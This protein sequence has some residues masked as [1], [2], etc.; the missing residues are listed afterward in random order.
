MSRALR[1]FHYSQNLYLICGAQL[2]GSRHAQSQLILTWIALHLA[3][4]FSSFGIH[5]IGTALTSSPV[6]P[7]VRKMLKVF[8][9]RAT[10]KILRSSFRFCQLS[11][12]LFQLDRS[13]STSFFAQCFGSL[14]I[15][16]HLYRLVFC[17]KR[18]P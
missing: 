8:F 13:I 18:Q 12:N 10:E 4:F 11:Y 3:P 2:Y 9:Q 1:H 5:R 15:F 7:D 16:L 6:E 14:I 17:W